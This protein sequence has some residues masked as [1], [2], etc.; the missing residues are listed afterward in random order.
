MA[1]DWYNG[2]KTFGIEILA[3]VSVVNFI[4]NKKIDQ[5]W[6]DASSADG[7]NSSILKDKLLRTRIE[8]LLVNETV[9]INIK[10]R[11]KPAYFCL[12]KNKTFEICNVD[13]IMNYLLQQGYVTVVDRR[14]NPVKIR[15]P[16]EEVRLEFI[17]LM[18]NYFIEIFKYDPENWNTAV[19]VS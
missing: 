18:T 6:K 12:A 3:T 8:N 11:L 2:Y 15:I 10:P 4:R 9:S 16:N 5:Y 19:I 14:D 17:E 1:F 7:V 13:L